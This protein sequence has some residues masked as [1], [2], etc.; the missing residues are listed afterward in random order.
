M[1]QP[2]KLRIYIVD[3][4]QWRFDKTLGK[5]LM[6]IERE[7]KNGDVITYCPTEDEILKIVRWWLMAEKHNDLFEHY[8]NEWRLE[9]RPYFYHI[10][11]GKYYRPAQFQ[12]KLRILLKLQGDER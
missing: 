1:A 4:G 2:N 3:T 10:R 11:E 12:R 9:K 6:L 8:P 7:A 5:E